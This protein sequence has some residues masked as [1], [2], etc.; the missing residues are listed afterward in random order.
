MHSGDGQ[1]LGIIRR[2]AIVKTQ[3][4]GGGHYVGNFCPARGSQPGAQAGRHALEGQ[5]IREV[6]SCTIGPIDRPPRA[7]NWRRSGCREARSFSTDSDF[8][9]GTP[10][11]GASRIA[12]GADGAGCT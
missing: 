2:D 6:T 8:T 7:K 10:S 5:E 9:L 11:F 12:A 1:K 3:E 4:A